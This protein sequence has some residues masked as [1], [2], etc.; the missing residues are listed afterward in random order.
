[1]SDVKA[2]PGLERQDFGDVTVLRVKASMLRADE[3]TEAL[4]DYAYGLVDTAGRSRLVLNLEGVA[5]M[6]SVG[7]GKLVSLMRKAASA[8]GRLVLCKPSRPV[9]QVLRVSRVS[10][11]LLCCEDEQEALRVLTARGKSS[12]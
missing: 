12:H 4:F 9:E 5:F 6:A 10:D 3:A 1:M 7:V 8:G 2:G 11:V